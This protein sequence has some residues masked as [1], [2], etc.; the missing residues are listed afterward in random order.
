[1]IKTALISGCN[2]FVGGYLASELVKSGYKVFGFDLQDN[3]RYANVEY[4]KLDL[5]DQ[6]RFIEYIHD[7]KVDEIYHLAAIANTQ[8]AN[9]NPLA[10]IDANVRGSAVVFEAA[11]L[12]STVKVLVVGSSEMYSIPQSGDICFSEDSPVESHSMYGV[13]K[14]SSEMIGKEYVRQYGCSIVF[15]RSF[16]HSGPGQA[17]SY[18]LS[19]WARQCALISMG[20][21]K[22]EITTGN[23]DVSRD[24]LDVR[25]VV[26]AYRA[27]VSLGKSGEIY[28]VTSGQSYSL[29]AVLQDLVSLTG[30][31]DVS[32]IVDSARIRKTDPSVIR[33]NATKIFNDTGWKPEYTIH[34]TLV[35]L[36]SYWKEALK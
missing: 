34:D 5:L 12:F 26:R 4:V 3:S 20:K 28:N 11:R 21:Q 2:G 8:T 33:G 18:V 9:E 36:Y 27:L 22:P 35:D 10:A 6:G 31:D 1:M 32:V 13:T 7:S 15:T 19:D 24:F 14:I 30:R 29:R 17:P 25:D 16:N 23:I